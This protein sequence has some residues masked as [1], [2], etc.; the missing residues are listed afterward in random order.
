VRGPAIRRVGAS[1]IVESRWSWAWHPELQSG[2]ISQGYNSHHHIRATRPEFYDGEVLPF[3]G[4]AV[5]RGKALE[6]NLSTLQARIEN[7]TVVLG[8]YPDSGAFANWDEIAQ[9]VA[10]RIGLHGGYSVVRLPNSRP[11]I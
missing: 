4:W 6:I 3:H 7:K 1:Q 10:S 11:P 2:H 8:V 9:M 5:I